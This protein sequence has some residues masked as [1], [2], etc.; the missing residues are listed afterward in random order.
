MSL[1]K[2]IG[3]HGSNFTTS[4]NWSPQ[5]TP[6]ST[7]DCQV[8]P[9][10][11]VA[12]S[13]GNVTIN[14]L[15]TDANVTLSIVPTDTFTILGAPDA[16]NP[17]GASA[18]GG[19]ILLGSA[20]DFFLDGQFTNVG[21]LNTAAGSDVWVNST[22]SDVLRVLLVAGR[23]IVSHQ[24]NVGYATAHQ[25]G[26]HLAAA[27][28]NALAEADV[29]AM[30]RRRGENSGDGHSDTRHDRRHHL[31]FCELR[32]NREDRG[33]LDVWTSEENL[34]H[35]VGRNAIVCRRSERSYSLRR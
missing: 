31:V 5:Q 25:V 22:L 21:A 12:I 4:S 24:G 15:V 23:A 11:P 26:R 6:T 13:A 17:T 9:L 30:I 27:Y 2:W 3:G 20:C 7:S 10:S 28:D 16:A 32:W 8:E 34:L 33:L 29:L 14:S 19:T 18:N 35:F 1:L